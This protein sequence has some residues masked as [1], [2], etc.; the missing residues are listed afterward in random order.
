MP[1]PRARR[2]S[3]GLTDKD[4]RAAHDLFALTPAQLRRLLAVQMARILAMTPAERTAAAQAADSELR[5]Q[6]DQARARGDHDAARII[7]TCLPL[8]HSPRSI[9]GDSSARVP[10]VAVGQQ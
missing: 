8:C 9:A 3:Y 2:R 5:Q 4:Y 1:D 6:A 10:P 7:L